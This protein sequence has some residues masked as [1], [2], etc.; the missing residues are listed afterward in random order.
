MT[1][2]TQLHTFQEFWP[3][4]LRQHRKAGCRTL[5]YVGTTLAS[6]TL[7]WAIATA[8][9]PAIPVALVVGYGFAW[10]GHFLIEHNRPATFGHPGWSLLADY[11]M[12]AMA[13]S[14]RLGAELER[15]T[16]PAART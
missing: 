14:G 6:G 2:R 12:L 3:F 15:A 5:H 16:D 8:T 10:T 13:L 9:W 7:A 11:K 1:T 4:Y